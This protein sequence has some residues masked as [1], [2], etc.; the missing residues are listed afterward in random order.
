MWQVTR[1]RK[2]QEVKGIVKKLVSNGAFIELPEG[3][4][5]F[6]RN[7]EITEGGE[8]VAVESLL[9][10]GQEVIARVLRN[11]RGKLSLTMKSRVDMRALNRSI[12]NNEDRATSPFEIF[13]RNAGLIN[14]E[15]TMADTKVSMESTTVDLPA[16]REPLSLQTDEKTEKSEEDP[17]VDTPMELKTAN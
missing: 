9:T 7:S 15:P 16:E 6:L 1:L 3:E 14:S 17:M 5:G 10:V 11:E 2:G 4:S 8:T 13:F 12:N